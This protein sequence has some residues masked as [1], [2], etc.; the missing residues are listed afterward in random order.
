M[1]FVQPLQYLVKMWES[2]LL[3][4]KTWR[5]GVILWCWKDG[6]LETCG[7]FQKCWIPAVAPLCSTIG[8]T[9]EVPTGSFQDTKRAA[10][11]GKWWAWG[12]RTRCGRVVDSSCQHYRVMRFLLPNLSSYEVDTTSQVLSL[13][14]TALSVRWCW[15]TW[16]HFSPLNFLTRWNDNS[17]FS[18]CRVSFWGVKN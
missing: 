15:K 6:R 2:D 3:I 12:S 13:T 18:F 1:F 14:C 17:S 9:S 5:A 10:P 7:S 16:S 4:P 11:V 8:G